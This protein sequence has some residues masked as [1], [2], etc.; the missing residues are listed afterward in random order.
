[1]NSRIGELAYMNI[2]RLHAECDDLGVQLNESNERNGRLIAQRDALLVL[3]K[4]A[5]DVCIWPGAM[6]TDLHE[7]ASAA[8]KAAE[9]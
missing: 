6:I 5:L 4:E 9:E 7:R 3:L 1:M 2:A 8:I